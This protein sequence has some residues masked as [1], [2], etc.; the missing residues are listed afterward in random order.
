MADMEQVKKPTCFVI[1]PISDTP[2]YEAG[3]FGRVY[4]HL[5]KPAITQAGF[6]AVRADDTNKTDYIVVG[7]IQKIVESEMVLCDFSARNPN[8]MYELGIRHAFDK[9]VVLIRDRNTDKVFDIQGLRYTEYDHSLRVDTVQKDI[10]KISKALTETSSSTKDDINSVIKLAGLKVAT[11]PET[12]TVSAETQLILSAFAS[13]E[14]RFDHPEGQNKQQKFFEI[15]DGKVIFQDS[16][17]SAID[18]DIY[19]GKG[20][21]V[22][23]IVDIHP[24]EEKIFIKDS[25]G[26][27]TSF[28]AYSV[29][30]RGLTSMPF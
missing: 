27:T 20:N 29:R 10:E 13:L 16:Y 2:G 28:Y 8:V 6:N 3:H 24:N 11:V 19:D 26:K 18:E 21:L 17:S 9:P 23:T 15:V 1:M 14:R 4:E 30:S 25:K 12:Q 22:G 5:L 7:I